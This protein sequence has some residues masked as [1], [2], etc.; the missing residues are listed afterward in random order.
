MKTKFTARRSS[1]KEILNGTL[2]RRKEMI[3][4]GKSKMKVRMKNTEHSN[5]NKFNYSL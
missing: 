4:Y 3:S 2:G 5:M 1:L